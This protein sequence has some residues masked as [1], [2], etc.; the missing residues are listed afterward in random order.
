MCVCVLV[1]AQIF[2]TFLPLV[3]MLLMPVDVEGNIALKYV[4][5]AKNALRKRL[6]CLVQ[7]KKRHFYYCTRI[8]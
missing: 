7:N 3:C 6:I 4:T 1:T 5:S 8:K 2:M